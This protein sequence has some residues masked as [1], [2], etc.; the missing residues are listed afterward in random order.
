M[1]IGPGSLHRCTATRGAQGRAGFAELFPSLWTDRVT[2]YESE[3]EKG[4]EPSTLY[5]GAPGKGPELS[6]LA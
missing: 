4:A 2:E 1:G 3:R 5:W 6:Q